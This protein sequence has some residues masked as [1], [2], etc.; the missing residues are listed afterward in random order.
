MKNQFLQLLHSLFLGVICWSFLSTGMLRGAEP[1][2]DDDDLEMPQSPLVIENAEELKKLSVFAIQKLEFFV[3]LKNTGKAPVEIRTIRTNCNCL[4]LNTKVNGLTIDPNETLPIS[5]FLLGRHLQPGR[6]YRYILLDNKGYMV[7]RIELEGYQ[8]PMFVYEPSQHLDFGL[9]VGN[10]PWKRS[11]TIRSLV[12]GVELSLP[13]LPKDMKENPWNIQLTKQADSLYVFEVSPNF[14]P[15]K[16]GKFQMNM[17]LHVKGE[18]VEGT[19]A[20]GFMGGVRGQRFL[21]ERKEFQILASKEDLSQELI[22]LNRIIPVPESERHSSTYYQAKRSSSASK[23]FTQQPVTYWPVTLEENRAGGYFE[24]ST[25]EKLLPDFAVKCSD[26]TL[27]ATLRPQVHS[28]EVE[29]VFPK[30]YFKPDAPKQVKMEYLFQGKP[31]ATVEASLVPDP[32]KNILIY[33]EINE[34]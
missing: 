19:I 11:I 13:P 8:K 33:E 12:P 10:V 7:Q 15:M 25:W 27:K 31:F 20:V 21:A 30:N 23:I 18:G 5:I 1:A 28:V 17:P 16:Q 4:E 6:F 2:K 14:L 22:W 32:K 9:F 3:K 26:E 29:V 34:D 24:K